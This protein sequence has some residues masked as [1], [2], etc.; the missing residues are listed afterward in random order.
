MKKTFTLLVTG[1]LLLCVIPKSSHCQSR[2]SGYVY[3]DVN[4]N[5]SHDAGEGL[6]QVSVWLLDQTAVSPYYQVYPVQTAVTAADGSYS[7]LNVVPGNY[8]VKVNK[9]TLNPGMFGG[10]SMI[11]QIFSDNN[12]YG[13][14][15]E[16]DGMTQLNIS[17]GDYDNIDF[18]FGTNNST[19]GASAIRRFAF[20]DAANSFINET[21]KTFNLLP[22]TCNG[23]TFFPTL[24]ISTDR[25]NNVAANTYPVAGCNSCSPGKYWPGLNKG[26]FHGDDVTFQMF[27]EQGTAAFVG[28][29]KATVNLQ[30]SNQVKDVHFTIYDIDAINPQLTNGSIDHVRVTGYNG[31]DPVMP[32]IIAAQSQPYLTIYGNNISG[33]PD[34]PDNNSSNNYPD[35]FNSGDADNGNAEIYFNTPID[36]IVIEYEEYETVL[37]PSAK[38]IKLAVSPINDESQWDVSAGATLRGISF[39]SIGYTYV[40]NTVL[41]ADQLKFDAKAIGQK[42]DLQWSRQS[43]S[44]IKTYR[45]EKLGSGNSWTTLGTTNAA[46]NGRIY[47]F[48]DMHPAKGLN[49][50]RIAMLGNNGSYQLSEIRKVTIASG[51]DAQLLNNPASQLNLMLY[52][53]AKNVAV[54]NGEGKLV[55]EQAIAQNSNNGTLLSLNRFIQYTGLYFV[56]VSFG[57]GEVKS[58]TY[59]KSR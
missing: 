55:V 17:A 39:G 2:I 16:P 18:G 41:A 10:P 30:F 36:K 34:Y 47:H 51:N 21:S 33:W 27:F 31:T 9:S 38:K 32:V 52:G 24:T 45:I 49:Q 29:D 35:S 50:Y 25:Q 11:T 12:P 28:N 56:K 48:P 20:D 42:V 44:G 59:L 26:G 4:R 7:F 5:S 13:R 23:S 37:L 8:E 1:I 57:N 6:S 19:P 15:A 22:E 43:E 14:D 46:G 58:L 40:C 53:D 54:Y 3:S